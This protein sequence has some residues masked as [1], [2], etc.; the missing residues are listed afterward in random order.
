MSAAV[1]LPNSSIFALRP[2]FLAAACPGDLPSGGLAS[3]LGRNQL[4]MLAQERFAFQLPFESLEALA[5]RIRHIGEFAFFYS[6]ENLRQGPPLQQLLRGR[7][8]PEPRNQNLVEVRCPGP[9]PMT[10]PPSLAEF[11]Y[12]LLQ[13]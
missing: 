6:L 10:G 4:D 5:R 12:Q 2:T 7:L 9:L 3:L 8:A 13:R 1:P 11:L